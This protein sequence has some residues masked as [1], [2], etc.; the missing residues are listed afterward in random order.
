MIGLWG[1][2]AGGWDA[3]L[4]YDGCCVTVQDARMTT[5]TAM[6]QEQLLY[7]RPANV[8][9]ANRARAAWDGD[10]LLSVSHLR[11]RQPVVA[12]RELAADG[13]ATLV[14]VEGGVEQRLTRFAPPWCVDHDTR[15][16]LCARL[17]VPEGR[18]GP[19]GPACE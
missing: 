13:S 4:L 12:R 19:P 2:S 15:D 5:T 7:G 17:V 6:M 8:G 9:L 16:M 10:R 1:V 18:D 3:K 14:L 11:E